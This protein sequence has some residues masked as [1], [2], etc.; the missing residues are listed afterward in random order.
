MEKEVVAHSYSV[1]LFKKK[2]KQTMVM[3]NNMVESQKHAEW[4]KSCI[5]VYTVW[6]HLYEILENAKIIHGEKKSEE[7]LSL[8]GLTEKGQERTFWADNNILYTD[9]DLGA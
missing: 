6:F 7:C 9:R 5:R 2:K 1:T 4:M 8:G 3:L